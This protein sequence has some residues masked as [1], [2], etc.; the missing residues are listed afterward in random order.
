MRRWWLTLSFILVLGTVGSTQ[1][2]VTLPSDFNTLA[3]RVSTL[4]NTVGALQ[5][6]L[7]TVQ[8]STSALQQQVTALQ[9]AVTTIQVQITALQAADVTD[10]A[11][12]AA[13]QT[14]V[15]ALQSQLTTLQQ[16]VTAL[17]STGTTGGTT[18]GS[19]GGGGTGTAT[20]DLTYFTNLCAQSN[21]QVCYSLRDPKQLDYPVN[22]GFAEQNSTFVGLWVTYDPANDTD[23][24]KQDAA[25]MRIPAFVQPYAQCVLSAAV[26]ATDTTLPL[27]L[28]NGTL[29]GGRQIRID[30]EVM[31]IASYDTTTNT[32][33]VSR[34]QFGTTP[35]SHAASAPVQ[36]SNDGLLNTV[37]LPLGTTSDGHSYLFI[38]DV[39]YTNSFL[40]TGLLNHKSWQI[41]A[42]SDKRDFLELQTTYQGGMSRSWFPLGWD[43]NVD[44][45]GAFLRAYG[46]LGP[47]ITRNDPVQPWVTSY[48]LKPGMWT[49]YFLRIDQVANAPENITFWIADEQTDPTMVYSPTTTQVGLLDPSMSKFWIE[50]NTSNYTWSRGDLR[51]LVAYI[52]DFALLVDQDPTALLVRPAAQ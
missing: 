14:Q 32:I 29:N 34:G 45:A 3:S 21:V 9:S 18:G 35:A 31:T 13:L 12:I 22:G 47:G 6:T 36:V 26:G 10:E 27:T 11:A 28:V 48:A 52:R 30:N 46:T 15:A 19:G 50:W 42:G 8:S 39:Y 1:S 43:P 23:P 38:W 33:A 5:A 41:S 20:A 37:R 51:D 4:E 2:T 16:Q 25:K 17:Q 24:Q 7:S 40:N 44:I 49:R